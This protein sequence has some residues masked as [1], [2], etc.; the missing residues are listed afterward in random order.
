ME[1]EYENSTEIPDKII[2]G[3]GKDDKI[4]S[5]EREVQILKARGVPNQNIV[6]AFQN[7]SSIMNELSLTSKQAKNL[8][9]LIVSG[10]TGAVHNVL[11]NV[12]GDVPSSIIGAALSSYIA[13]KFLSKPDDFMP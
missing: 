4:K 2:E 9:S 13:K 1:E 11:S 5:L 3:Y 8:R 6:R 10:G 12:I 7:P